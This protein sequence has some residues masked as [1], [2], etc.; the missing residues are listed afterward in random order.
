[1]SV[2]ASNTAG[3]QA[4]C[5]HGSPQRDCD[6]PL[7]GPSKPAGVKFSLNDLRLGES[8]DTIK[9][10]VGLLAWHIGHFPKEHGAAGERVSEDDLYAILELMRSQQRAKAYKKS[11]LVLEKA[12]IISRTLWRIH[13]PGEGGAKIQAQAHEFPQSDS[14]ALPAAGHA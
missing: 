13:A 2:V 12:N 1:M 6:A 8:F 4:L 7:N 14:E 10:D 9:L 11:P 3:E 5:H